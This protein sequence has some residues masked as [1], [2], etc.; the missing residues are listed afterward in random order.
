SME[1]IVAKHKPDLILTDHFIPSPSLI[2]AGCPWVYVHSASALY[3]Y[4]DPNTPPPFSGIEGFALC[5][6]IPLIHCFYNFEGYPTT[7]KRDTEWNEFKQLIRQWHSEARRQLQLWYGW[8]GYPALPEAPHRL[9]IIESP[10]LN[11]YQYPKELD[12]LSIRPLPS[13][14]RRVDTY[15]LGRSE[16][17]VV[18]EKFELPKE[19]LNNPDADSK[20]IYFSLGTLGCFDIDLMKRLL[21]IFAKS[22]HRFIVSKGALGGQVQLPDNM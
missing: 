5:S 17:V 16:P 13:N 6:K 20:L 19:F 10:F 22:K 12:Y 9:A 18:K 3:A 4:D 1:A 11:I 15:G 8:K 21:A 7:P 14:W 2:H